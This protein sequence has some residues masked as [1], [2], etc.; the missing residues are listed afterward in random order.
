MDRKI[1][2][3]KKNASGDIETTVQECPNNDCLQAK[4]LVTG[5]QQPN[6]DE[7]IESSQS[8]ESSGDEVNLFSNK[9]NVF[10]YAND[11]SY[12]CMPVFLFSNFL[13][14]TK[15]SLVSLSKA[16]LL[17]FPSSHNL[18]TEEN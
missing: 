3:S 1:N 14:S 8:S 16:M 6:K 5:Q 15:S 13:I 9:M 11:L 18:Q 7:M 17:C 4:F 10:N 12:L 2:R